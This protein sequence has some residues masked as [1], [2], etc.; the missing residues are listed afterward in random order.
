MSV[1][2]A[3]TVRAFV[4]HIAFLYNRQARRG[5]NTLPCVAAALLVTTLVAANA[6][7]PLRLDSPS[8]APTGA[9]EAVQKTP[10]GSLAPS[11]LGWVP[12]RSVSAP[13]R[14]PASFPPVAAGRPRPR[15]HLSRRGSN[16]AGNMSVSLHGAASASLKAVGLYGE[17]TRVSLSATSSAISR[18]RLVQ[19]LGVVQSLDQV[20]KA[21]LEQQFVIARPPGATATSLTLSFT[22]SDAWRVVRGGSAIQVIGSKLI[23]GGLRTTDASGRVLRSHFVVAK[24]GPRIVDRRPP[25]HLSDHDR[26][27]L[28]QHRYTGGDSHHQRRHGLHRFR[29]RRC[30]VR[31]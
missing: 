16:S 17:S 14:S 11:T 27:D 25:R 2:D 21:G 6:F 28:D 15:A 23:Y 19:H 4:S 12:V 1:T 20:T 31:R 3:G 24:A 26:P 10:P 13:L 9:H 29:I 22:S 5:V 8:P 30:D 18:G 7:A